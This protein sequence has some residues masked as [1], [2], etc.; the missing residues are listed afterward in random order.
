VA[1]RVTAV[2]VA[3]VVVATED[4]EPRQVDRAA[5]KAKAKAVVAGSGYEEYACA[6]CGYEE[7]GDGACAVYDHGRTSGGTHRHDSVH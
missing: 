3:R 4:S 1:A 7:Y 6:V 2:V 5:A